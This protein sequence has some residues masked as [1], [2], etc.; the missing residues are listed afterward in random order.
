MSPSKH[1]DP[2]A[3]VEDKVARG[4]RLSAADGLALFET[5]DVLRVGRLADQVRRRKVG[6]DAYFVVN[7]HI[8]YT[9]ICRNR[10]RFCAFSRGEWERGAYTLTVDEVVQKA[11]AAVEEGATEIHIVGGE[12]P[13]LPFDTIKAMIAGIRE[14][15]PTVHIKAFTASEIAFFAESQKVTA[16]D[17]LVGLRAVGLDSLPGGGAEILDAGVRAQICPRKISGERWLE[18]HTLAHQLGFKTTATMLYGHVEM[19][20]D[21]VIH[22]LRLRAL[23]DDTGGF[24]AF[25]P[26]A[27]QP[28]N[29]SMADLPGTTG[30][31]DLKTLAVARLLLDNVPHIKAYWVMTGLK[32]AQTALFFG[33]DDLDGTV[34]EEVISLMSEA[35]HGQEVAKAELIRVIRNAKR[36]PVE[37]DGVYRVVRRYDGP[38]DDS[39]PEGRPGPA[40]ARGP[41]GAL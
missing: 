3:V 39:G 34:V 38:G 33:A 6:D 26:L 41:G 10:C 5:A 32:L 25:I 4:E 15:A 2:L 29:S 27:F 30:T 9:N 31:D 20:E 16:E 28:K 18:I 21:R 24:Q 13:A 8:N 1:R 22:L 14:L 37:R 17:V 19:Y 23:Q 40:D 7:R 36:V 11:R 12:N 35:G